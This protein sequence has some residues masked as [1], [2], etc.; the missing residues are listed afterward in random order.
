MREVA[1]TGS[2]LADVLLDLEQQFP[3]I[4]F[5]II[6]EQGAIRPHMR[7]FVNNSQE[8]DLRRPLASS[9][10]VQLIQ[11]LSGG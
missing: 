3:G 5:R 7:I 9:D 2:T 1:A 4:R 11:A 8:F 10:S 6:D